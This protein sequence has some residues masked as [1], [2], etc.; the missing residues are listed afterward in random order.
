MAQAPSPVPAAP[1]PAPPT[2]AAATANSDA[3]QAPAATPAPQKSVV[4][5]LLK[6]ITINGALDTYYEYNTNQPIGRINLLRAYDVSANSFSLNQADLIIES[7]PDPAG[8]KPFGVRFDLQYGQATAT[9]QGNP[10]NELRPDLYRPIYQAFG[11]YV[12][13]VGNGLTVD[14]GKWASSL[15]SEGNYTKD[16][17]NYSRSYW[18]TYLPYYHM[19]LRAKYPVNDQLTLNLWITNGTEQ[20]EAFNN[21]KDQMYGAVWTPSPKFSWTFNY[22]RGQEHPDVVYLQN[23][24]PGQQNLP[25]QQGTFVLPIANPPTGLLN[26]GDTYAT[27]QTTPELTLGAE[28]DYVEERLFSTSPPDHVYGG[29]LYAA[30]QLTPKLSLAARGEYLADRGGLFSGTTQ[31]LKEATL[32]LGYRPAGDGFLIDAEYRHDWSDKPYFLTSQLGVLTKDQP[33]IGFG[34]VWWFGQKQG[35]W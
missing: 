21:Y 1:P 19:G 6:G 34:V 9:L 12:I 33:T 11:T 23:P 4:A 22:Y 24:G 14:F 27:W 18:F 7:A 13:P 2:P 5:D 17:L 8:G 30:Y 26:I 32:T 10:A 15:G 31:N 25:N 3:A 28:G 16:Q 35:A 20:T 29:A